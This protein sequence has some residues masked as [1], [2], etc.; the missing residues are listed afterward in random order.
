MRV[1]RAA[2][3]GRLAHAFCNPSITFSRSNASRLPSAFRT[4][5]ALCSTCS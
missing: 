1:S 3:T 2:D 4:S 5:G